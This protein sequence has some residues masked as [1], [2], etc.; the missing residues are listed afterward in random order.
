MEASLMDIVLDYEVAPIMDE[1]RAD[2]ELE[3]QMYAADAVAQYEEY[4]AGIAADEYGKGFVEYE[5]AC[6][7]S[8]QRY[9]EEYEYTQEEEDAMN[10]QYCLE[11]ME[12]EAWYREQERAW[13]AAHPEE[14]AQ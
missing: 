1:L 8:E 3:E 7:D 13:Y 6:A 12:E 4:W 11:Q 9:T 2:E 10:L 5:R 14:V